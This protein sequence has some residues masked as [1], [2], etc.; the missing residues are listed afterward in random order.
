MTTIERPDVVLD[1]PDAPTM[2]GLRFRLY[3][4]PGDHPEM[5]RI[6][7]LARDTDG[8]SEVETVEETDADFRNPTHLDPYRD[9]LVAE[10]HG[11]MVA[12]SSIDWRD[13]NA[14]GRSYD[15][16]GLV[17]PAW[18]R[19]GIGRAM[20]RWNVG[21]LREIAEAQGYSGPRW[22]GTWGMDGNEGNRALL[23][24]EGYVPVRWFHEMVRPNLEDVVSVPLPPGI[25]IR[26]VGP[27]Q[28]RRVFDADV[29]AFHDHWGAVDGSDA[30]FRRWIEGPDYDPSLFVVAWDGDEVA[31]AVLNFI[32]RAENEKRGYRRGVLLHVF[33][34]RQWRRR[35]I[36]AALVARSLT[37]LRERGMTSASLGVDADNPHAAVHLYE[38]AG[39]KFGSSGTAYNRPFNPE[40]GPEW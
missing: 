29:E 8:D 28:F 6:G 12:F 23:L 33:T 4:G 9:V 39:F 38:T 17:D 7:N 34:R 32:F 10:V 27:E 21:R 26:P 24:A 11:A 16:F 31:S 5:V 1:L 25:E 36:A 22:F 3:R 37:L 15:S 2:P 20:L 14:G 13:Q 35:G 19:R 30:S 40:V 18:R